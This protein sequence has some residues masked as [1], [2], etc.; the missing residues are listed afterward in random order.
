LLEK[1][2]VEIVP[3]NAA[4]IINTYNAVEKNKKDEI[5]A[6]AAETLSAINCSAMKK[7]DIYKLAGLEVVIM[8]LAKLY[9]IKAFASECWS[10][11]RTTI[12][13]SPCFVFGDLCEKG[14]PT[15]VK[16]MCTAQSPRRFWQPPRAARP[17]CSWL[18]LP[19]GILP[20]TMPNCSGTAAHSLSLWQ[21]I[22]RN[23]R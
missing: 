1:F 19:S 4:E 10:I 22:P 9:G 13:I 18:T 15:A 12:G 23:V 21:N 16:Q 5:E 20:M 14:L 8:D 7:E 3:I 2:N 11:F 6:I 17:R